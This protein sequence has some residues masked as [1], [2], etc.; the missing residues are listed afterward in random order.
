VFDVLDV[1]DSL[2]MSEEMCAACCSLL[3]LPLSQSRARGGGCLRRV[4]ARTAS[5]ATLQD[6]FVRR[7][8]TRCRSGEFWSCAGAVDVRPQQTLGLKKAAGGG[9][10]RC[11]K[12][13]SIVFE[14]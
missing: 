12:C 11:V 4:S 5:S 3:K 6:A 7:A 13:S 10:G 1:L 9:A 8:A 14:L 2:D